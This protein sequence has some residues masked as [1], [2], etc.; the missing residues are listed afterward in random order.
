MFGSR[1]EYENPKCKILETFKHRSSQIPWQ[2]KGIIKCEKTKSIG[3]HFH[4]T[5]GVSFTD[6]EN[7]QLNHYSIQSKEFFEK[8]KMTRGDALFDENS[9]YGKRNWDFFKERDVREIFDDE[10]LRVT[11]GK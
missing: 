6:N 7:L 8:I 5:D 2:T 4:E 10:I 1:D 9:E 3:I 11:C